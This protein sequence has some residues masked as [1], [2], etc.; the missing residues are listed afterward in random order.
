[1]VVKPAPQLQLVLTLSAPAQ[2]PASAPLCKELIAMNDANY[3]IFDMEKLLAD[4]S[5]CSI[6][7]SQV[8]FTFSPGIT[9]PLG[10]CLPGPDGAC[11]HCTDAFKSSIAVV[12]ACV[13][14]VSVFRR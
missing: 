6:N 2:I 14:A 1:M 10:E 9:L 3:N 4:N 13:P 11:I 8:I 7:G 12:A 5:S